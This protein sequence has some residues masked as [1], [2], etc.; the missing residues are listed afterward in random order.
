MF[1]VLSPGS[2]LRAHHTSSVV[3]G[4]TSHESGVPETVLVAGDPAGLSEPNMY[5]LMFEA[6]LRKGYHELAGH[7]PNYSYSVYHS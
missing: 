6:S 3:S 2:G 4:D 7:L 1:R 5:T